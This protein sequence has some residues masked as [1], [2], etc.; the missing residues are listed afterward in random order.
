MRQFEF[1]HYG[2]DASENPEGVRTYRAFRSDAGAKSHAG[3]L[4]RKIDGPV[5]IA[6]AGGAAWNDRYMTTANP[7]DPEF[8]ANGYSFERL[9]S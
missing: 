9:D 2:K 4:A 7:A 5:D 3:R 6:R 8:W 1:V